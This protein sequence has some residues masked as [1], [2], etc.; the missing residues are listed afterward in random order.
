MTSA[1][2]AAAADDDPA[3]TLHRIEVCDVVVVVGE[4]HHDQSYQHRYRLVDLEGKSVR[5]V[6]PV[7]VDPDAER[8]TYCRTLPRDVVGREG[9]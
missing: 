4:H 2:S 6:G 1:A 8:E 7:V 9:V 3:L 5:T